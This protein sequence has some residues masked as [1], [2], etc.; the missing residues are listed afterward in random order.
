MLRESAIEVGAIQG[1]TVRNMTKVKIL[2]GE[3]HG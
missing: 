2:F 1:K 3:H